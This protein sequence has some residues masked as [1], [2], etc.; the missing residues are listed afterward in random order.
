VPNAC[1]RVDVAFSADAAYLPWCATA[2]RSCVASNPD[3]EVVV[4]LLHDGSFGDRAVRDRLEGMTSSAGGTLH[5]HHLDADAVAALPAV[6]PF[7]P[8]AWSRF[9]LPDLLADVERILYLDSDTLVV[10][11]IR[12]LWDMPLDGLPLAAVPNVVECAMWPHVEALG[13]DPLRFLNTGVL[14]MDL[15][16]MRADGSHEAVTRAAA[17][18]GNRLVWPDQDAC[19]V[20]LEGRWLALHP[21]WNAQNSLWI[22]SDLARGVFGTDVVEEATTAPAIL[23][24]EGPSLSKPWH[25]LCRHPWRDEY[26]RQLRLTPFPDAPREDDTMA[27]R[28]ISRLP[29]QHQLS[30][31]RSLHRWRRRAHRAAAPLRRK[32]ATQPPQVAP[33]SVVDALTS[34]EQA[35]IDRCRPYSLASAERLVATMDAVEY[36][37]RSGVE[38]A[39]VECGVWK[40]GS[41]LAMILTLQRLGVDDRD[42]YLFDTFS[43]MTEPSGHDTSRFDEPAAG[44]WASARSAGTKAWDWLF[45]PDVFGKDQVE[46][47]LRETGYPSSRIHFVAG[48]VEDTLPGS[49]PAAVAVLRLDTD[50]YESTRQE[51]VHLYPRL[52]EGGVLLIDD[53]GHWDGARRAVDEYFSSSASP[54]LLGR[55]DYTG[56]MAVKR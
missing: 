53:Y 23:H 3:V 45:R 25:A 6:K 35:T 16:R 2:I 19:N 24:F 39:L 18:L 38:G 55:T 21:R 12:E 11:P 15:D 30:A 40:G 32:R 10:G 14:L 28:L 43:G 41:V 50:W 46:R 54:V 51:L 49:A 9:L 37:V 27:T 26:W 20:A 29:E 44:T 17:D 1:E 13:L 8:L 22:W 4:H 7:G 31:Y 56:R 34:S 52:R 42:V 47:L 33:T 36:V 5:L 48:P